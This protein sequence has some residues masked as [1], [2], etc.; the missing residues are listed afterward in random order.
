MSKSHTW[1]YSWNI[2]NHDTK[3]KIKMINIHLALWV[4][5]Q[6]K[7]DIQKKGVKVFLYDIVSQE[8]QIFV[9]HVPV[10]TFWYVSVHT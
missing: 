5:D 4:H 3:T 6:E 10:F 1:W 8:K 9:I 7:Q 2:W